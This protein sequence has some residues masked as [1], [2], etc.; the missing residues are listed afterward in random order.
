M[1]WQWIIKMWQLT[2]AELNTCS[3]LYTGE[4]FRP[5]Y[6]FLVFASSYAITRKKISFSGSFYFPK[7]NVVSRDSPKL[8]L[9]SPGYEKHK[10]ELWKKKIKTWRCCKSYTTKR[11]E[12]VK[13]EGEGNTDVLNLGLLP[14]NSELRHNSSRKRFYS[15]KKA[16]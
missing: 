9:K 15:K 4:F 13:K 8:Q 2:R 10:S 5:P 3:L 14:Y 7:A 16:Y 12:N 1:V 6:L 11:R